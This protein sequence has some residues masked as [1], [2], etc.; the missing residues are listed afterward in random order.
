VLDEDGN[1]ASLKNRTAPRRSWP[2]LHRAAGRI[3]RSRYRAG[4]SIRPGNDC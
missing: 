2:S 3:R 1:A 4:S